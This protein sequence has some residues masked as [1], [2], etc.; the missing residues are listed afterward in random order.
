MAAIKSQ[1]ILAD[2]VKSSPFFDFIENTLG[3]RYIIRIKSNT[4]IGVKNKKGDETHQSAKEWLLKSGRM[5]PIK[6]VTLTRK[7]P[8]LVPRVCGQ[9]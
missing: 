4:T 7:E 5:R 9:L 8:C 3:F 2:I 6:N 1:T